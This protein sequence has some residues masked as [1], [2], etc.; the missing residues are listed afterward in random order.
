MRTEKINGVSVPYNQSIEELETILSTGDMSGFVVAC[1]ALSYKSDEKA[2]DLL[3]SYITHKD[4][5]KRLCVLKTI[6]RHPMSKN[7]KTFLEESILSDD[8]L[9]ADNGL[10]VVCEYKIPISEKIILSAVFK[11]LDNL[12]FTHLYA[13]ES[14]SVNEDNF[15]KLVFLFKKSKK[16]GQ[17]EVL[18]EILCN[19]YLPLKEV[20]LFDLFSSD[21]FSKIR[22]YA[23]QRLKETMNR[24]YVKVIDVFCKDGY[25]HVKPEYG[26]YDMIYRAA[27]GVYW[28]EDTQTLYYKGEV[29]KEVAL[30]FI[31]KAMKEEYYTILDYDSL[32]NRV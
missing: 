5:Y 20:E 19:K 24:Y 1:E 4:K 32:E 7:I 26:K 11:H 17:K 2:F 10:K 27:R 6:F 14:L 22:K 31:S 15:S 28:D 23:S 30:K 8:I 16:C 25:F 29:S 13:L 12:Y 21:N 3:R 9:F 18:S